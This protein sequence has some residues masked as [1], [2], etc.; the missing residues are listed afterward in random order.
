MTRLQGYLGLSLLVVGLLTVAAYPQEVFQGLL[1]ETVEI[2]LFFGGT[3]RSIDLQERPRETLSAAPEGEDILYGVIQ[4]GNG[5]DTLISLAVRLGDNPLIWIDTNNNEDLFD[6]GPATPDAAQPPNRQTW[7]REIT[8]SYWEDDVHSTAPYALR[9][10]AMR[11]LY[12][13]DINEWDISY[14]GVCARKGLVQIEQT[15]H[16]L[17]LLDSDADGLFN[18]IAELGIG[19][20]NDGDGEISLDFAAHEWPLP[21]FGFREPGTVQIGDIFYELIDVSSDG[22]VILLSESATDYEPLPILQVGYPAPRFT[23]TSITGEEVALSQ[24]L[25]QPLVI[26]FA[27]L[28]QIYPEHID[29]CSQSGYNLVPDCFNGMGQPRSAG[30]LQALER[31]LGLIYAYAAE[32]QRESNLPFILV[33]TDPAVISPDTPTTLDQLDL[34]FPIIWDETLILKYRSLYHSAFVIDAE[35]VVVARDGWSWYYDSTGRL[36]HA[37]LNP[38]SFFE[39]GTI[40]SSLYKGEL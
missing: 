17:W 30:A 29:Y 31:T 21:G 19:V 3:T 33:A 18:D 5:V 11:S 1:G 14:T 6:D 22:R 34:P 7:Y 16:T 28:F 2:S 39:I 27:P 35:G 38:L 37:D 10:S 32:A 26:V 20:D 25:G 13:W 15:L 9:L 36:I 4:L 12:E 40:L 8:V 23:T 24:Y